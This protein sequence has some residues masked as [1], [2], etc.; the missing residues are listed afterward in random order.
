MCHG[1]MHT[2]DQPLKGVFI[3]SPIWC[4]VLYLTLLNIHTSIYVDILALIRSDATQ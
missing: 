3:I 4:N 1:Y 2:G